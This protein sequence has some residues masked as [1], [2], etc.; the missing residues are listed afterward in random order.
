MKKIVFTIF[1]LLKSNLSFANENNLA[2][3]EIAKF[4]NLLV[5]KNV[6]ETEYNKFFNNNYNLFKQE[7]IEPISDFSQKY[8]TSDY[9]VLFYPF[10]GADITY[11]L[12]LFPNVEKI[13]LVGLEF[14]GHPEVVRK[15]FNLQQF[16]PQVEGFFQSGFFK[17]MKM[18]AQMH[19]NQGVIPML[20]AQISLLKGEITNIKK[21]H[22]PYKGI[23][24]EFKHNEKNKEVI[25]FKANLDDSNDKQK[26]FEFIKD[27]SL[28]ENCM[29][30]ASSY[31]LH[32]PE[33]KQLK[34]FILDSCLLILQDDTGVPLK[35]L[36]HQ[37]EEIKVFGSYVRPYGEEFN[38]YYQ[39]D[40]AHLF[41]KRNEVVNLNFCYGYGCKKVETNLLLWKRGSKLVN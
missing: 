36:F 25:Y 26:F 16:R 3:G 12:L 28:I 1:L 39:Q 14:P 4:S 10:A 32:Q 20:V 29:L 23:K 22:E 31:K 30:K 35:N 9:K 7:F 34:Q 15:K 6:L 19:Y 27:N 5:G 33:F 24:I 8:I 40:L 41:S 18:S 11:P 37:K 2:E 21:V 13:V 38:P 17:T